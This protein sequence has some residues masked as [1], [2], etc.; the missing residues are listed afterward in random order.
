MSRTVTIGL[1]QEKWYPD[2]QE[3]LA[4]LKKG[5]KEAASKGA[6]LVALQEL[7]LLRYFGDVMDPN[8][9]A[10]AEPLE[11]GPTSRFCSEVAAEFNVFVVGS[12]FED[13]THIKPDLRYNTAIIYGPDGKMFGFTRK[14]H[15][16]K[17]TGYEE[18]FYFQPGDSDYPVH[19]LGFI[20][21]G[22]PTCYDQ[23]FP[24]LA[25][26]YALKGAELLLYPTAIGSEP[27]YPGLDTEPMWQTMMV[28]H[29]ICN[30]LFIGAINRTG[31]EAMV[32][33]Y[34][35][36]FVCE[37]TGRMIA[38]ASRDKPEVV[39]A[40]L[41]FSIRQF[42]RDLFP[43]PYQRQPQTYGALL[44]PTGTQ[45]NVRAVLLVAG[46]GARLRPYT[47]EYPKCMVPYQGRPIIDYI[48][49]SLRASKIDDIVMIKGYRE[50]TLHRA[51]VRERVNPRFAETNMVGSLFS[52]ESELETTKDVVMSYGDIV[53]HPSIVAKLLES[54]ADISVIIDR[55][56]QELWEGRMENP[57]SDA[58]TLKLDGDKIIEIGKKPKSLDEIQG[59]YI[60]LVKFSGRVLPKIRAYYHSLD[61]AALYDGKTFDQ[62]YMT[63]FLQN[64]ADNVLP[65]TAVFIDGGWT[66]VD[67]P[68]DLDY[69]IDVSWCA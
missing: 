22:V 23:W 21:I 20:K 54:T 44:K 14:Q 33:F 1:V 67:S 60:G 64:I 41:D 61:R 2:P 11:T 17:G 19:D 30:G 15:I 62:M 9:F 10:L 31:Q 29:G 66:E 58:E 12:I 28:S 57:L 51:G 25:R 53:Y 45:H 47:D 50:E 32:N 59:Q 18:E 5:V 65:L 49:S 37:P 56:W 6:K 27:N 69:K 16:P 48:L 24:E 46:Q 4:A 8:L 35:S 52:A 55:K 7:T 39:V 63:S 38:Q 68:Q 42:W 43:L 40:T 36:T 3:H 13:A 26:I 34:G